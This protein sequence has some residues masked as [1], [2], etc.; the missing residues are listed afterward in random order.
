MSEREQLAAEVELWL[1]ECGSCD[2]ALPMGCTCP[3]GDYRVVLAK[4]W[5]AYLKAI[6]G[7]VEQPP[8]DADEARPCTCP[9]D[10][11]G[12]ICPA[13][14]DCPLPCPGHHDQSEAIA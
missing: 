2:A 7:D 9:N 1:R 11:T 6:G 5:D 10:G 14:P 3:D 8:T 12:P 13:H 4:V